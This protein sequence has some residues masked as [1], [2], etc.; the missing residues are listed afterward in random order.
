MEEEDIHDV[1]IFVHDVCTASNG[2]QDESVIKSGPL[3]QRPKSWHK[4]ISDSRAMRDG[5]V[6]V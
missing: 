5:L 2:L 3:V 1:R 6:H 4:Q